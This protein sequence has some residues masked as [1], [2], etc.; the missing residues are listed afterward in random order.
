MRL[1]VM[2]EDQRT[3]LDVIVNSLSKRYSADALRKLN[4]RGIP[5]A[6]AVMADMLLLASKQA[7]PRDVLMQGVT[8]AWLN[9]DDK[10]RD[11]LWT[12]VDAMQKISDVR[13]RTP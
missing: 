8:E 1:L 10:T 9:A 6:T 2:D 11:M 12:V 4:A 3:E 5:L 7:D 13:T